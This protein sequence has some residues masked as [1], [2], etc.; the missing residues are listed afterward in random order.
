M[1]RQFDL[2]KNHIECVNKTKDLISE[3][4]KN[5]SEDMSP[6]EIVQKYLSKS[7]GLLPEE[8]SV[9]N[10]YLGTILAIEEIAK[11]DS[12]SAYILIDQIVFREIIKTYTKLNSEELLEKGETVGLLC[13]ESGFTGIKNLQTKAVKTAEGWQ[14]TG[15]KVI[16][17]EQI[18]S[19]KFVIFAQDEN[20]TP[21]LFII[22]E[23]DIHIEESKKTISSS[24]IVFNHIN[25]S[26][27]FKDEENIAVIEDNFEKIFSLARTLI[28]AASVGIAHSSLIKGI[29]VA[30]SVKSS[31]G[32]N[33]STSQNIQ[34]KLADMFSEIEASRMLTYL[35]ADCIDKNKTN[36][37]YASMAK[38]KASE[39]ASAASMGSLNLLGNIGFIANSD[40]A[41]LIQR[42][43]DGQVKGGT[44]RVQES[45]IYEYML[46]KK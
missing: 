17:N 23:D 21:R 3:I 35:S 22:S 4:E 40:F 36:I 31:N 37:K 45:Q 11:N 5:L 9:Y 14:V 44:N 2:G 34:F 43:I 46:A 8:S 41:S 25:L 26:C 13:M 10:D 6:K 38:V 30:K 12:L 18:Y 24:D 7:F 20:N 15:S 33:L 42:S 39:A 16:S 1:T 28:A 32:E 19:D 29:E 27:N